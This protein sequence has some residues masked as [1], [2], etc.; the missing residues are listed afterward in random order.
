MQAVSVE[1]EGRIRRRRRGGLSGPHWPFWILL[2][3]DVWVIDWLSDI[4]APFR[5]ECSYQRARSKEI[6]FLLL[7][8]LACKRFMRR[9]GCVLECG[10]VDN[11]GEGMKFCSYSN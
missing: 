7:F 10:M 8:C 3:G 4:S 5:I 2:V 9:E 11:E 1:S 6:G